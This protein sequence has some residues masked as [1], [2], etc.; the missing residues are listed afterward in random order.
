MWKQRPAATKE[1]VEKTLTYF[2]E[3]AMPTEMIGL[4]ST[5]PMNLLMELR[6]FGG[7]IPRIGI[8]FVDDSQDAI[9]LV[10]VPL[11]LITI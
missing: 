5:Q 11:I 6:T 4:V 8:T 9:M 3:V 1:T 7:E 2:S 10:Q